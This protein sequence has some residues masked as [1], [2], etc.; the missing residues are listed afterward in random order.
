MQCYGI[1]LMRK[2]HVQIFLW[3]NTWMFEIFRRQILTIKP[4]RC[5]SFSNLFYPKNKFEK[6]VHRVG[7]ILRIYHDTRPP[8]RQISKT[9]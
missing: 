8:G 2:L 4:T 9:L 3:M 6:L 1:S 7:F 5:T